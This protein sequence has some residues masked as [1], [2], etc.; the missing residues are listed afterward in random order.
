MQCRSGQNFPEDWGAYFSGKV[1]CIMEN[2]V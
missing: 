2:V 1:N